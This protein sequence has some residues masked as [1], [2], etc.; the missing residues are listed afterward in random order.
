LSASGDTRALPGAHKRPELATVSALLTGFLLTTLYFVLT[1]L[2]P[3]TGPSEFAYV[4]FGPEFH[5]FSPI[6]GFTL[7]QLVSHVLR[8]LVLG[9]GLWLTALG[10]A[11]LLQLSE[12]QLR[13]LNRT[14][15]VAGVLSLLTTA[16]V[17]LFVLRGRAI[18]DDEITY[19]DMARNFSRGLLELPRLRGQVLD[20]FEV[21]TPRGGIT[22]KYLFGEPLVQVPGVLVGMPAL[23][24]LPLNALSLYAQYQAVLRLCQDRGLAAVSCGLLA[25]SPMFVL[26][27]ATAQSQSSSLLCVLL[28]LLGYALAAR[29][30]PWRGGLLA[31]AAVGFGLSVRMQ[32]LVP[33]GAVVGCYFLQ[34]AWRKRD[35]RGVLG[36]AATGLLGL[37]AIAGYN[38]LV[39]GDALK[40][41]WFLQGNAVESYGFVRVWPNV[42]FVHT[43]LGAL[44]N[45]CVVAV[46]MNSWWLGWPLALLLLRRSALQRVWREGAVF[47]WVAVALTVFEAG[48]YST[49]ISEVGPIYHF[50]LLPCLSLVGAQCLLELWQK[51]PELALT[52][53]LV[54]VLLGTG[55]FVWEQT[56]RLARLMHIVQ[57]EAERIV[58]DMPKQSLLLVDTS[59]R[60]ALRM[61]WRHRPFALM[62][63]DPAADVM[64]YT[65]PSPKHAD[66]FIAQFPGRSCYYLQRD[67][68]RAPQ[69]V[70][71]AA[72]RAQLAEPF[73]TS[74]NECLHLPSSAELLRRWL[75]ADNAP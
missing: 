4:P 56:A 41:P 58:A 21:V 68:Q 27:G 5:L 35:P 36:M 6:R 43:P 19:T 66:A 72:A 64:V 29:G 70:P 14:H 59:C 61:G 2:L 67:A 22:G 39:T 33:V 25:I 31:G 53:V 1:Q 50:E 42:D 44:Q 26:C 24:H 63:H 48:Y 52:A 28:C 54:H 37:G 73:P 12:L 16:S 71:C 11:P 13:F 10:M 20:V 45:L 60:Q 3:D 69:L 18:V 17:M 49:G 75:V 57:D 23:M 15:F 74:E 46:R 55:S 38:A 51:R 30:S 32:S 9:P 65:R 40:L 8:V 47:I 34:L 7:E 62:N